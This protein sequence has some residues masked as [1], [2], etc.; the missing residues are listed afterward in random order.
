M[1]GIDAIKTAYYVYFSSLIQ[2]DIIFGG[3]SSSVTEVFLLQK[4]MIRIMMTVISKYS[5]KS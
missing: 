4:R 3:N 2:Y 1:L 5:C